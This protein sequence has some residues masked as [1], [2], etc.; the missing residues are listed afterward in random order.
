MIV[1]FIRTAEERVRILV[2]RDDGARL[3]VLAHSPGHMLPHDLAHFVVEPELGIREGFW[4]RIAR[5]GTFDSVIM[6]EPPTIKVPARTRASRGPSQVHEAEVLV[7]ILMDIWSGVA[8][9]DYGSVRAYLDSCHS[10]RTRSRA[11]ELDSV[12]IERVC[13]ALDKAASDWGAISPGEQLSLAWPFDAS[14]LARSR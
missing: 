3:E 7:G 11:E 5:G 6:L 2:E 4:G 14:R 12:V 9:R 10:P 1:T 13:A 8:Q